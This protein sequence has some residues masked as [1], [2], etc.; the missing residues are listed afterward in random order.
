MGCVAPF[1]SGF[2]A[3]QL[4]SVTE[5]APKSPF[6]YVR[7]EQKPY[8]VWFNSRAIAIRYCENIA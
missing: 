5:I 7:G 6:L 1:G 8:P 3:E 4:R 2:G